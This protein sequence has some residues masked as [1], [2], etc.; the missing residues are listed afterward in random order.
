[1]HVL[2]NIQ[3]LW[4]MQTPDTRLQLKMKFAN[5]YT[6]ENKFWQ[7]F[8]SLIKKRLFC[9]YPEI[10]KS[11]VIVST[12]MAFFYKIMHTLLI[13]LQSG[14]QVLYTAAHNL[15]NC[16]SS[17]PLGIICQTLIFPCIFLS[18][19]CARMPIYRP[20]LQQH[21]K[22][23]HWTSHCWKF[24]Q[25]QEVKISKVAAS[26]VTLWLKREE[27]PTLPTRA[28]SNINPEY[29]NYICHNTLRGSVQ[30]GFCHLLCLW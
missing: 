26:I 19:Y 23:F 21:F 9:S 3:I 6:I 7:I 16:P 11:T 10:L 15:D 8:I 29:F 24:L 25:H 13:H 1:M 20:P 30:T 27:K 5:K 28:H 12:N 17:A 14:R 2:W 18:N 4:D 22:H